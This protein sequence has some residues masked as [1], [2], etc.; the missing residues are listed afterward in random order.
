VPHLQGADRVA[1]A[2][3]AIEELESEVLVLDDGFQHRR[4]RRDLDIV[5]LDATCPWGFGHLLPR[6]LLREQPSGLRRAGAI[7][8]TRC[9][10]ATEPEL[11]ALRQQVSRHARGI[12]VAETIHQPHTLIQSGP[13]QMS[14]TILRGCA[15]AGLCGIGNPNSFRRTLIDLGARLC[16]FRVYP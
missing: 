16:D 4:L 7:V 11:D 8:L 6:G 13:E 9:D 10:Q 5:L 14:P 3:I 15:V 1:L 12:P 2:R